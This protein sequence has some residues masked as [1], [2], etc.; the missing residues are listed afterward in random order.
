LFVQE[1]PSPHFHFAP[2]GQLSSPDLEPFTHSASV[3]RS[4]ELYRGLWGRQLAMS[5]SE[6]GPAL[7]RHRAARSPCLDHC[8][9]TPATH[10]FHLDLGFCVCCAIPV[11]IRS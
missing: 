4:E 6:A 7:S 2:M 8:E 10:L 11:Q 1:P 3:Q 5:S 9:G